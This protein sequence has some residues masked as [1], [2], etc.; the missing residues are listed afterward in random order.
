MCGF[1]FYRCQQICQFRRL[2]NI[3]V[4]RA[5]TVQR[6]RVFRP[7]STSTE[8][9]KTTAKRYQNRTNSS[10]RVVK[11]YRLLFRTGHEPMWKYFRPYRIIHASHTSFEMN[12]VFVKF[13]NYVLT[14]AVKL[15]YV[16]RVLCLGEFW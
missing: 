12:M 2:F 11:N 1:L 5:N 14:K 15:F 13:E 8:C 9:L 6:M 16:L 7:Y 3:S 4:F 10:I